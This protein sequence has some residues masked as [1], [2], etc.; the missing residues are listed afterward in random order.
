MTTDPSIEREEAAGDAADLWT[1][2]QGYAMTG[3]EWGAFAHGHLA[4]SA[5]AHTRLAA[6]EPTDVEVE[7]V[8]VLLY[9]Q[10]APHH[11]ME[12]WGRGPETVKN[13][14]R[15]DARA[16]LVTARDARAAR[17]DEEKRDG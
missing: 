1:H 16:A 11:T 9:R 2:Q 10:R 8:A 6:Q 13:L 14:Y 15:M 12:S 5:W 17:R 4:G 7:A 3:P